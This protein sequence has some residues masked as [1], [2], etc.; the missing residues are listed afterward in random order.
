MSNLT[1]YNNAFASDVGAS[2][3]GKSIKGI[4]FIKNSKLCCFREIGNSTIKDSNFTNNSWSYGCAVY[5]TW[6]LSNYC[7]NSIENVIVSNSS[8][9]FAG[10]AIYY[11]VYRPT[12][13]NLIFNNNTAPYGNNIASYAVRVMNEGSLDYKILLEDIASGQTIPKK[14]V[15][16][17][18]DYDNQTIPSS[19]S[20]SIKPYNSETKVLGATNTNIVNGVG[21]FNNLILQAKPGSHHVAFSVTSNLINKSIIHKQFGKNFI[22]IS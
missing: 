12:I 18:V 5:Y 15:F 14:L 22:L 9:V 16:K 3:A 6:S 13:N 4:I 8:A 17:V 10:G 2:L 7:V 20:I 11:D 19:G 1:I 21:V